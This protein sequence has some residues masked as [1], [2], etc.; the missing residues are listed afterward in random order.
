[1]AN[2]KFLLVFDKTKIARVKYFPAKT[3]RAL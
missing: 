3:G 2:K 1:M